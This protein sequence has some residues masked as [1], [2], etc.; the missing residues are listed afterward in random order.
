MGRRGGGGGGE[1]VEEGERER[2]RERGRGGREEERGRQG[3]NVTEKRAPGTRSSPLPPLYVNKIASKVQL[4][5]K[6]A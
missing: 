2:E 5:K 4:D 3:E 1:L 6:S